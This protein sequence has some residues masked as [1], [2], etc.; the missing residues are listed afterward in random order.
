MRYKETDEYGTNFLKLPPELI[1]GEEEWEVEQILGKH[2]FGQGKKV[3]Y[4][5]RWKG[6]LLAHNQWVDKSDITAEELVTI[7]ERENREERPP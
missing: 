6:Y 3:Q 7:Y 4:L 5:M 2:H 1:E